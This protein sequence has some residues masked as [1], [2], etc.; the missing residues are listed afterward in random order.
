MADIADNA[1]D[2]IE[3]EAAQ[4]IEAAR[5]AAAQ[6]PAGTQGDCDLCGEWSGRLVNGACAPCRDRRRFP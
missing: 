6:M 4:R 3:R 1:A 2:H 5:K